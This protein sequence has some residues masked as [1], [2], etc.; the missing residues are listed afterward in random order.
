MK[1]PQESTQENH[2][3][4]ASLCFSF[5]YLYKVC[6]GQIWFSLG[7]FPRQVLGEFLVKIKR[8]P[9]GGEKGTFWEKMQA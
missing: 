2:F 1:A 7:F 9:R 3:S 5:Y 6:Q 4:K 8:R